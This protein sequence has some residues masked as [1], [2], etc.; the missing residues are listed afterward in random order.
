MNP[1]NPESFLG[2]IL[3]GWARSAILG[4]GVWFE[5]QGLLNHDQGQQLGNALAIVFVL[6][7]QAYDQWNHQQKQNAALL[8]S[9][10]AAK[11]ES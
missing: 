6:G 5:R 4:I 3:M 2:K 7:L 11:K 8:A 9:L 1:F 10:Q